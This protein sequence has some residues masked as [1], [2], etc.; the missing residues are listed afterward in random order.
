MFQ[1][2]DFIATA[3]GLIFAV[4]AQGTEQGKVRCFLRYVHNAFG[5]KKV[6]TQ[7]ANYFLQQHYPQY[8]YDSPLLA[9]SLHAVAVDDIV[10][11]Y[12]P[13][14]CLQNILHNKSH[15]I[16]E[17]DCRVLM[18]LLQQQGIYSQQWGITGS[19]LLGLHNVYSDIDLVCYDLTV[20]AQCRT[21]ITALIAEKQLSPLNDK[22][23]QQSYERRDC[24]LSFDDY[25]WHERRKMNKALINGRKFDLSCVTPAQADSSIAYQKYGA[26]ILQTKVIDASRAFAYPAEFIIDHPSIKT[27]LCFTATYTGQAITG[28]I[29]E[30]SGLLEQA[31]TGEQ[32]IIVGSNREAKGEYIKV[33]T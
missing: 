4:V 20:F 23:W 22:D 12:I 16:I 17:R 5:W 8:L 9:A 13:S 3:E 32:R 21:A 24:A 14:D 33:I 1:V 10:T 28:E 30:V 7:Q 2:K 6:N 31:I 26:M 18:A 11:H 25:V 19:L 27:V 29:I 15:D